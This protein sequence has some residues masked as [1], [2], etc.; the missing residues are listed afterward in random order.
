MDVARVAAL[1]AAVG[2][3]Q[4]HDVVPAVV[5]DDL[6]RVP[7]VQAPVQWIAAEGFFF[8]CPAG[9][10]AG[11]AGIDPGPP[12][13]IGPGGEP[14]DGP[15]RG[16]IKECGRLLLRFL[17]LSLS[18]AA[19]GVQRTLKQKGCSPRPRLDHGV[20]PRIC[21]VAFSFKGLTRPV[22]HAANDRTAVRA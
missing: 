1:R 14:Q 15:G 21:H 8:G 16:A 17:S 22:P 20:R 3:E 5:G 18:L 11:A 6:G 4:S 9:W 19:E 10:F 13:D 12:R 7:R 2:A